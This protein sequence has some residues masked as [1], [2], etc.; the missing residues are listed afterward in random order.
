[1][2]LGHHQA[3]S[4]TWAMWARAELRHCILP[5]L[6]S[7]GGLGGNHKLYHFPPPHGWL[8]GGGLLWVPQSTQNK[9]TIPK[10]KNSNWKKIQGSNSHEHFSEKNFL[11]SSVPSLG[12]PILS[13][14]PV[15]AGN[16]PFVLI[17]TGMGYGS[18]GTRAS[19]T[20]PNFATRVLSMEGCSAAHRLLLSS[21][22]HVDFSRREYNQTTSIYPRI[23][24]AAS[25]PAWMLI[26][27]RR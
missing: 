11:R 3:I 7:P 21:I 18:V 26:L 27:S 23:V 2:I 19:V 20:D 16:S 10:K 24:R 14:R 8:V 1:M 5:V 17:T 6:S 9:T 25:V 13:G 12:L 22:H 4:R 15:V